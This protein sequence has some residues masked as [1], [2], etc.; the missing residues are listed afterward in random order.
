MGS[1]LVSGI[2]PTSSFSLLP[3]SSSFSSFFFF[4]P[5]FFRAMLGLARAASRRLSPSAPWLLCAAAVQRAAAVRLWRA[6]G[7]ARVHLRRRG[8]G[9]HAGRLRRGQRH[10]A[11]GGGRRLSAV[12]TAPHPVQR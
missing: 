12:T 3:L 2:L 4:A 8:A 6:C 10:L 9:A 1:S 11:P 5:S 7:Y